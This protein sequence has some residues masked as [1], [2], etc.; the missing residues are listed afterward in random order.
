MA[1]ATMAMWTQLV[2]QCRE[3][4]LLGSA[5]QQLRPV[6]GR[7]PSQILAHFE[8]G[9]TYADK[10][11]HSLINELLQLEPVFSGA[12]YP[13]VLV[14]GVAY[15]LH[16][17]PFAKGRVFSDLDLLVHADNM[18]D[19]VTRLQAAGFMDSTDHE[20]DRNYYLQWSHQHPPLRHFTRGSEVDLH[21]TIFFARSHVQVNI[22]AFI[23]H[24][25]PIANSV[26]S[27]PSPADM[28]VHACLHLFYQEESHKITKD[29]IDLWGIYQSVTNKEQLLVAA[30][31]TN[32][33]KVVGYAL[34][35]LQRLFSVPLCSDEQQF[36]EQHTNRFELWFISILLDGLTKQ[37]SHKVARLYWTIRGHLIKMPWHLLLYHLAAKL[38]YLRQKNKQLSKFQAEFDKNTR[39]H[40]A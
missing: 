9:Q 38:W 14:K 25:Q 1:T 13:V 15:R 29:L 22:T 36:I 5:Y 31:L 40:D 30:N 20:Y 3:Q 26:F 39:P 32:K 35:T 27:L 12:A 16:Q 8:S 11:Y 23:G 24:A 4:A 18:T 37:G 28:F 33:P 10:Q 17:M 21:H 6:A 34:H 19:A 7:I 2:H